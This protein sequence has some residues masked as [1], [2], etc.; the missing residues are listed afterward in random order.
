MILCCTYHLK[1]RQIRLAHVIES[2]LGVNPGIILIQTFE[3][4]VHQL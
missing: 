1:E 4:I 2:D 3:P